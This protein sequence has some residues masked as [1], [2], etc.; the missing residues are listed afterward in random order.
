M[1]RGLGPFVLKSRNQSILVD[2]VGLFF[3]LDDFREHAGHSFP[4]AL[5]FEG[6]QR[7]NV[8]DSI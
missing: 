7:N 5:P 8:F 3:A 2:N 4:F 6:F 1:H